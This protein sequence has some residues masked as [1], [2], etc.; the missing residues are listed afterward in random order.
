VQTSF[1]PDFSP[2]VRKLRGLFHTWKILQI[3]QNFSARL[4]AVA[5]AAALCVASAAASAGTVVTSM[6]A[7]GSYALASNAAVSLLD[8]KAPPGVGASVDVLSFPS[9][10]SNAAG[11]HS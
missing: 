4:N 2:D 7:S 3:S 5:V 6:Q 8:F 1:V 9:S 10:G 11:L